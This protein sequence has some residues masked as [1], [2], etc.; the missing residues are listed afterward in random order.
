[1]TV[2][3]IIRR[4]GATSQEGFY[5]QKATYTPPELHTR[6]DLTNIMMCKLLCGHFEDK[7][8]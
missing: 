2:D 1:M 8:A 6:L 4:G 3:R 5:D 7:P